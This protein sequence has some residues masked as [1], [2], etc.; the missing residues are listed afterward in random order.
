MNQLLNE[1]NDLRKQEF[2]IQMADHLSSEDYDL[3][4]SIHDRKTA[5]VTELKD[6][7]GIDYYATVQ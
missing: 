6:N 5:I 7:Y 3:L 1:L 4:H 2:Y